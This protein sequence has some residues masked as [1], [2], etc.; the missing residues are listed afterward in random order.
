M[1]KGFIYGGKNK[2]LSPQELDEREKEIRSEVETKYAYM[3]HEQ[4]AAIIKS[5]D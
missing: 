4:R 3:D 1:K 5:R 2:K